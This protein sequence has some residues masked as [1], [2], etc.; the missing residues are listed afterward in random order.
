MTASALQDFT[1]SKSHWQIPA[2]YRL[3][4]V[5]PRIPALH[6]LEKYFELSR[7]FGYFSNFG[8]VSYHFENALASYFPARRAI[9][10]SNCTVGLSAALVAL[11]V[12]GS[13]LIP[14][15][16]FAAT[17]SAVHAA[18]LEP[19]FGDVDPI[20]GVLR[21][22][23]VEAA[24]R[25][26][27]C[28]AVIAVRPYGLWSD[29]SDVAAAC[30]KAGVPLIVDGAAALG[31]TP[32]VIKRFAVPNSFEAFSLHS[33][34]PFGIGEGGLVVVPPYIEDDVRSALNFGLWADGSLPRGSGFNGKMDELSAS[35]ACAVLEDMPVR[36]LQRQRFAALLNKGARRRGLETFC[37]PGS[38]EIAPWQCFPVRLPEGMNP[39]AIV[40]AAG[41]SGL[42]I[43]RYYYPLGP[44]PLSAERFPV[45]S[46]LSD[47]TVCLPVYEGADAGLVDEVWGIFEEAIARQ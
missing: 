26:S 25:N 43:R 46:R 41:R 28:G 16:T 3:P 11:R 14:A 24:T 22:E 12:T 45:A 47:S 4:F 20:T 37:L 10:S 2:Q 1:P 31:V 17:A 33:T 15:F 30:T 19:L 8:P 5:K 29:L 21:A 35:M 36:A 32:Q 23:C 27:G 38:E 42:Q 13:V 7:E 44:V 34:K 39:E 18:G 40:A 6:R 9:T